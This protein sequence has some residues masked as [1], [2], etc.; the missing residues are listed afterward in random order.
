[1]NRVSQQSIYSTILSNL[2]RTFYNLTKT[3]ESISSGKK[4]NRPSDD[5]L[6][7]STILS[8]R[9]VLVDIGQYQEDV[10]AGKNL[11]NLSE[12]ALSNI[13]NAV[14]EAKVLTEQM[15]T[16]TY[17]D[18]N[19]EDAALTVDGIIDQLIQLGN[20]QMEGRY[21]FAGTKTDTAPFTKDLNILDARADLS[22]TSAYTGQA[23]SS[24]TYTGNQS[25]TYMVQITTAGGAESSHASLT[26]N[27]D[28]ANDDLTFTAVAEGAAGDS[29]SIEYVDP[30]AANQPLGVV[31]NDLGGGAYNIQ[32]RLATDGAG[33]ITSTAGEVMNAINAD[34]QA[35]A[36]VS[37]SLAGGNDGSGVVTDMGG[38]PENLSRGFSYATL[39]TDY[40][41]LTTSLDG[42]NNDL[43]FTAR[44]PG[45]NGN[46]IRIRFLDPGAA[47]QGLTVSV[48]END[49]T[50]SLATDGTGAITS[51]A[52]QVMN[53]I[54]ADPSASALVT[55]SLTGLNDGTGVVTAMDFSNLST[56][57]HNNLT[58]TALTPG[59]DGNKIT[60]T[61]ND[62]HLAN[63]TTSVTVN[64][65][66][67]GNYEILVNLATDAN[68]NIIATAS[69]V[70]TAIRE[71]DPINPAD[72]AAGDLV[73]VSLAE[74][75]SGLGVINQTGTWNLT[76]GEDTAARFK[77]SEDGGLTWGPADEFTA[78][79]SGTGIFDSTKPDLDQGVQIAF[80]N[81]GTLSIGDTFTIEVSHYL[82]NTEDV[83]FNIQNNY[84][85]RTN[86][87][88]EE[89]MGGTGDPDNILDSLFRL[90]EALLDHDARTV[91][92]E[93]PV[94]NRALENLSSQM[95]QVG[96]RINRL[97]ISSNILEN[98]QTQTTKRLSD[99]EDLDLA[100]AITD[101]Q[102][103]QTSYQATL[104][105]TSL[106][107][108]LSLLDYIT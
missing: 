34:A 19:M 50:I 57:R 83:E 14:T 24:G 4:V 43:A 11:L 100:K 20:T 105:S 62:P 98:M 41:A 48:N 88:G 91:A 70:L 36:L 106:I 49:I 107:T 1:M 27:F 102:L 51:T 87:N 108:S 53:A 69:D 93:L 42:T 71:H 25:K 46:D 32:V 92:K 38:L 72:I 85:V 12:S 90:K 82:G 30:L 58:F 101:L 60:I 22:S 52:N 16:E 54:N 89:V 63:Q 81:E 104:A 33:A 7:G 39:T 96:V 95:A 77:V 28:R 75:N 68:G 2:Q 3:N 86:V 13:Q 97:E 80:T 61:Y 9:S 64:N 5:P 6:S 15:S 8:M 66:G 37:A 99:A 45:E 55:A 56:E 59:T 29:I 18:S 44:N 94:L 21:I 84:R 23:T 17:Q 31:V 73:D 76:G 67:G 47:N 40:A 78:S 26:T 65:L 35:S 103:Q 79:V 74:T 10:S